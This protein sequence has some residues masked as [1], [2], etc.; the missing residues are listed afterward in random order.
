MKVV[1]CRELGLPERSRLE[2]VVERNLGAGEV[3]I[4]IRASGIN[5]PDLLMV[6]AG[7]R[8]TRS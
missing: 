7:R 1:V 5:F 4:T 2:T 8:V 6:A 3:R